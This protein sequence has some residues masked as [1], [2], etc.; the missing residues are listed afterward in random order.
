MAIGEVVRGLLGDEEGEVV[1][2]MGDG[3]WGVGR[4]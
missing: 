2:D 1:R 3:R 4:R